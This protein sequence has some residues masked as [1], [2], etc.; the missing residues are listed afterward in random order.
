MQEETVPVHEEAEPAV[1]AAER[2]ADY[3]KDFTS[4]IVL[5]GIGTFSIV[6]GYQMPVAQ[7]T[8][9]PDLWYIAPGVSPILVGIVLDVLAFIL[10]IRSIVNGG[11]LSSVDLQAAGRYIK[12][13]DFLLLITAIGF[14]AIY[15]FILIGRM[16][17]YVATFIYLFGNMVVFKSKGY[18][19][20]RILLVSV[21][22]VAAITYGFGVMAR[23]PLP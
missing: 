3:K 13:H 7:V 21:L 9:S 2:L 8:G 20:W 12:T 11:L 16:P 5:L 4:S 19:W 17:Y 22:A 23:I 10:L 15:I 6:H 18:P 14:L 1:S